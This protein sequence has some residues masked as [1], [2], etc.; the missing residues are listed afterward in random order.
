MATIKDVAREAKVG[1]ATVSRVINN[2]KDVSEKTRQIVLNTIERLQYIPNA[3]GRTLKTRKAGIIG[4][5]VPDISQKVYSML[6]SSITGALAQEGYLLV[7]SNSQG[8]IHTQVTFIDMLK[9]NKLDGIIM[10]SDNNLNKYIHDSMPIV[11]IDSEFAPNI[12]IVTSDNDMGGRLAAGYLIEHGCHKLGYL[13]PRLLIP[14]E[15]N[16]RWEAFCHVCQQRKVEY[17]CF[18]T[19]YE[20]GEEMSVAQKFLEEHPDVDGIFTAS[21]YM[22]YS[23]LKI[24]KRDHRKIPEEVQVIGFDGIKM[25]DWSM[26]VDLTTIRQ[27]ITEMGREL[28]CLLLN[29]IDK[30]SEFSDVL[31]SKIP[32]ELHIGVTTY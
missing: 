25:D 4:L 13:G 18:L 16:K 10:V 11:S 20:H 22:A 19:P 14:S 28:V 3:S 5:S 9:Q 2:E 26:E 17:C 15:V 6:A 1:L 7:V 12:P 24:L 31:Q 8:N 21:D 23:L 32:V 27:N 29:R 30:P